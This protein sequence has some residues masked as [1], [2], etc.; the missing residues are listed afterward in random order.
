MNFATNYFPP[1][2]RLGP[3]QFSDET[4]PEVFGGWAVGRI[5]ERSR[6]L[7]PARGGH[8]DLVDHVGLPCGRHLLSIRWYNDE[9]YGS[10]YYD[11]ALLLG[12]FTL[13]KVVPFATVFC[14]SAKH[15]SLA[16]ISHS[17]RYLCNILYF[18]P[19]STSK[20]FWDRLDQ[21]VVPF[22]RVFCHSANFNLHAEI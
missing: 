7:L 3:S 8:E 1:K 2:M 4:G 22:A 14:H 6:R 16:L 15:S 17:P 9:H 13:E 10:V 11:A 19:T 20:C 21:K 12:P 5:W 18:H